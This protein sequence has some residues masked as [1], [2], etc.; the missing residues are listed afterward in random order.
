M[1]SNLK[2][3]LMVFALFGLFF[4]SLHFAD[5][6]KAE[7]AAQSSGAQS[8]ALSSSATQ[9]PVSQ[10][11]ASAPPVVDPAAAA[12]APSPAQLKDSVVAQGDSTQV[13]PTPVKARRLVVV[14]PE[15]T[16]TIDG[17]GAR[18]VGLKYTGLKTS[19]GLSPE[20]LQDT[21]KGLFGL[22]LG[23]H[24]FDG[25]VFAVDSTL[26][27]TL[28]LAAG[29]SKEIKLTWAQGAASIERVYRFHGDSLRIG[30]RLAFKNLNTAQ[31]VVRWEGGLRETDEEKIFSEGFIGTDYFF[32]EAVLHDG[33]AI[34]HEMPTVATTYNKE[35]QIRWA[36]MRRKYV[37]AVFEFPE[38]SEAHFKYLP[39]KVEYDST[40]HI[41]DSYS[42]EISEQQ[43]VQNWS[44]DFVLL[45]LEYHDL[46]A[47]N[48][49]FEKILFS[50][51]G[52][53][54]GAD[55]WFPAMCG[56]ILWMLNYF[57]GWFGNYGWAIILLTLV[58]RFVTL[59][60]TL[61][62]I[63]ST[64]ALQAHKPGMDAL[65]EKYGKDPRK[66]QEEYIKYLKENG[67]NPFAPMLGC[68]PLFLQMPVFIALFVVLSRALELRD[69]P[70]YGWITD[71]SNPDII[72]NVVSIPFIMPAG[73]SLLPVIMAVTTWYQTKQ[74]ITDPNMKMMVW[75]MPL[76]MFAFSGL[77]PSGLVIYWIVSNL[78]S[79]VQ[80]IVIG[81]PQVV[82]VQN[83]VQGVKTWQKA[84]TKKKK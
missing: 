9:V 73:L 32:S 37:A 6:Q 69:Q 39:L 28:K 4:W 77:M 38:L 61:G 7:I 67:I 19:Q 81:K 40:G 48:K 80:Y 64:R 36:G 35:G 3:F 49:E 57:F 21:A 15:M 65:R 2:T 33:N 17:L 58:V 53:F 63:R 16:T 83:G 78:F 30:Q 13:A 10:P 71:L 22:E 75:M 52:W 51:W 12:Q 24:R 14:T 31:L 44:A 20:L 50:G 82:P 84:T 59:P 60:L 43:P 45:P 79:I 1:K 27:D 26:P 29:E 55:T 34:T 76:M 46:K 72:T 56:F 11:A 47:Q 62:Q 68:L 23:G 25:D 66:Y 5:Q 70:F 54:F 8:S 74:T 18:I 41:K 42:L